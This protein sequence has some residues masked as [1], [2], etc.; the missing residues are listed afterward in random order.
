V[1]TGVQEERPVRRWATF[2]RGAVDDHGAREVEVGDLDPIAN[3]ELPHRL[4]EVGRIETTGKATKLPPLHRAASGGIG[5]A[6]DLR[7]RQEVPVSVR[8]RCL[9]V[10]NS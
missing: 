8:H 1:L 9:S 10:K 7:F 2:Y 3:D 4:I 6:K 5:R